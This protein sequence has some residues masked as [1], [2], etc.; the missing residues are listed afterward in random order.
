MLERWLTDDR[1]KKCD[2]N[3]PVC[4]DCRRLS[5]PCVPRERH[6]RRPSASIKSQTKRVKQNT[7][8]PDANATSKPDFQAEAASTDSSES[9]A[10]NTSKSDTSSTYH[11]TVP[12]AEWID[13]IYEEVSLNAARKDHLNNSNALIV[14]SDA[15]AGVDVPSLGTMQPVTALNNIT[16]VTPDLLT[17]WPIGDRHLLNHF[18]QVV[19]R[20]L[21]VVDDD[22]NPF[23]LNI[24]PMIFTYAPVRHALM[25][26][27]ACQ[28]SKVYPDFQSDVLR[29]RNLSL[30]GLK[31]EVSS[32]SG[33]R[34]ALATTL[35]LCLLEVRRLAS[36]RINAN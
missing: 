10:N 27:S 28:L 33:I 16:G 14:M 12:Y 24:V 6:T 9:S 26:L 25:A 2:E 29:H 3:F 32:Q 20:A 5:I 23:L 30:E 1:H 36:L 13:L 7:R 8:S 17:D 22:E 4:G 19:S 11:T 18:Q 15:K 31:N 34:S 35:L 21:V